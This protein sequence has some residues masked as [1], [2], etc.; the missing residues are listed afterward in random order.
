M[1]VLQWPQAQSS[2]EAIW[3]QIGRQAAY[4]ST[5]WLRYRGVCV[6]SGLLQAVPRSYLPPEAVAVAERY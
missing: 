3:Q 2:R 1:Q 6:A 5:H 4:F